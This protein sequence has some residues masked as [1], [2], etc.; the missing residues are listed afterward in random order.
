MTLHVDHLTVS[1]GRKSVLEGITFS[2]EAGEIVGLTG[3]S[4]AGK[5]LVA[6][7]L[8]GG[9]AQEARRGGRITID[10]VPVAHSALAL[11]P[12]RLDALDPLARVGRQ[13]TRF[14][15][16]AGRK[17]DVPHALAAVG[18]GSEVSRLFPHQLSGGMARRVVL[19]TALATGA[20]WLVVDEPTV[21]LND[22]A[23]DR[24]MALLAGLA[25]RGRG[26]IV[27][28]H[29]LPRLADVAA[30]IVV[31]REGRQIEIAPAAAFAGEGG[32]LKAPFSRDLWEAQPLAV[33]ASC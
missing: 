18:L 15:R 3:S 14:A 24:I 6:E 7:A 19:A 27:I 30:R 4:G 21:G 33:A 5:T 20:D 25:A 1:F 12:Q 23:A 2:L 29:D 11:A 28:S 22:E 32:G 17:V 26:V 13:I 10:G 9:L 31:M 8:I 16:L